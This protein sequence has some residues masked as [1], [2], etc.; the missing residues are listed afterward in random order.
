MRRWLARNVCFRLQEWLKGH[1]TFPILRDMEEA[2][3]LPAP[4]LEQL[5]RERLRHLLEY[6]CL[7]VPYVRAMMSKAGVTPS[8]IRGPEDLPRLPIM[9]K[10]DVRANDASLRST[11]AGALSR[12]TTGG[13]TGEP[14]IFHLSKRRI[15]SRVACRQRVARW[16]GLSVGD[17]EI[18]LWGS[19]IELTA[20]DWIRSLRDR[21]MRTRL[22]SAFEMNESTISRYL[23][24]LEREGC[25]QLFG[26]PSAVHLLCLQA[27]KE[28]RDLRRAGVRAVFVTGE[29]LFP[30]QREAISETLNCPV[31]D[32]YGGRDSGFIAHEC[33]Q[34]GMHLMADAVVTEIVDEAG[35]PLPPGQAG[36][37]VVTDLY[38]HE[39]PFI[40]YATGDIGVASTARC[41]CGRALPLLERI[42]GRSN[43]S[44]IAPDGRHINSLALAYPLREVEGV[45]Q[46]QIRQKTVDRFEVR[47]VV[48]DALRP[49]AE[50][51]IRDK[52]SRLLRTSVRVDFEYVKS[53]PS[54]HR[55][56]FRHVVSDV[57]ASEFLRSADKQQRERE[58]RT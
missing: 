58:A 22:L 40:R 43:D 11:A 54:G 23:D 27:R 44:I 47:W 53:I 30:H 14:L 12:F 26:Y 37:I 39:Y 55:G 3:R 20:Q 41:G 4:R 19:P 13:S 29:T 34:G 2:D 33:P 9:T 56:K 46:Y 25:R 48:S 8:E 10:A 6:S 1:P 17:P 28:K 31:A 24:V 5:Q 36:Q 32:G 52:W 18:A 15:A 57:P 45:V 35:L 42:E 50:E 7:H 51:Q 21:L 49:A 16:W 38:S